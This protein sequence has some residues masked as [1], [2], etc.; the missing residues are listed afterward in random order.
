MSSARTKLITGTTITRPAD[1]TAY[2]D[3]DLVANSVT[4]GSVT[5]FVFSNVARGQGYRSRILRAGLLVSQALLANGTFRLHLF[6][7]LPTVTNGDNG[8]LDIASNLASWLGY[9]EIVLSVIGTG[10]GA[11]GWG[12]GQLG[13]SGEINYQSGTAYTTLWGLLEAKAAY[14]P[15][16]GMTLTPYLE[17]DQY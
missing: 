12:A 4:A 16:S 17:A 13:S 1:I 5:P 8:A 10:Q 7:S 3:K 11:F 2:A 6:S 14:A 9:Q 15:T